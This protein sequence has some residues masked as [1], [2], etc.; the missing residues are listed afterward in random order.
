MRRSTLALGWLAGLAL[1]GCAA[2]TDRDAPSPRPNPV[3]L[4]GLDGFEWGV[5]LPLLEAGELPHL[6]RLIEGGT[7]GEL[8]TLVP[9][10]SP[11]IWT[12]VVTGMPPKI[13]G[14]QG[15][16]RDGPDGRAHPESPYN[17]R[18]RRTKALWNIL[19]DAGL[20]P[21]V[22]GW[23]NTYPAEE[24]NGVV[25][26]QVNTFEP[27]RIMIDQPRIHGGLYAGLEGQIWPS[28]RQEELLRAVGEVDAELPELTRNVYGE[29]DLASHPLAAKLWDGCLWSFRS[30]AVYQRIA[31]GLLA[32]KQPF[33][34]LA[35]YFGAADVFGHR[36]WRY[37]YPELFQVPPSEEERRLLG[38]FVHAT[39]RELDRMVGELVAAAPESANILVLSD[40]GMRPANRERA[41]H[42][43]G[44]LRT[45]FS[46]A[47]A[48]APPAFFVAA[49]PDIARQERTVAELRGSPLPQAGS[50]MD[51]SPTILV[52]LGLPV[53]SDMQG[54]VL[55][56]VLREGFLA[57]H[58]V[59]FVGSHTPP[60]WA[61]AGGEAMLGIPDAEERLEQL[62]A[63]GYVE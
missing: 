4:I 9:T 16:V 53:G 42:E 59:T 49:G 38:H 6:A 57:E 34:F 29:P 54:E 24:V 46:A 10:M 33:D 63:L 8:G 58:P 17:S 60:D 2:S 13:H 7:S 12:T 21:L 61:H 20:R 62:R 37:A 51:M 28:E 52:L 19:S 25:V 40:H 14:I 22:I 43:K 15:F 11:I 47:H 36:F 56:E 30:D 27:G 48:D 18:H 45:L 32:E 23:W 31:L 55:G 26:A 50:V 1:T 41:F 3:V 39:Y 44:A 35:I 5:A